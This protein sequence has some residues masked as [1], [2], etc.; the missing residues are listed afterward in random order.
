MSPDIDDSLDAELEWIEPVRVPV[1]RQEYEKFCYLIKVVDAVDR[2]HD[3]GKRKLV[4]MR[5]EGY[6]GYV[7]FDWQ[8]VQRHVAP[9]LH[10]VFLHDRE[11]DAYLQQFIRFPLAVVVA[12]TAFV[13]DLDQR[14]ELFL[15]GNDAH[16]D[17]NSAT[18]AL[19]SL[20]AY[21]QSLEGRRLVDGERSFNQLKR[22]LRLEL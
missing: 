12:R 17:V 3:L 19:R 18:N 4:Q 2:A 8:A 7:E 21:V 13:V 9:Q 20:E 5:A 10:V 22:A 14:F 15:E 16:Q 6:Q 11:R 1:N